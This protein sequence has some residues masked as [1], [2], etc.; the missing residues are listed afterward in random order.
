MPPSIKV[1]PLSTNT[2]VS[3]ALVFIDG[4]P[5][6][7]CATVSCFTFN[8]I[9]MRWSGVIRGTTRK[10]NTAFLNEVEVA[11]LLLASWNGIS[12]PDSMSAGDLSAVT[13]RA[14]SR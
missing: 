10:L 7:I 14:R 13:I 12:T 1:C 6:K 11:R 8:C 3:V 9:I 4:M 2:W 5:S